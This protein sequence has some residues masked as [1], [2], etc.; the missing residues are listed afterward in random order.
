MKNTV[1]NFILI[2]ILFISCQKKD[3]VIKTFTDEQN[4]N[5]QIT[6]ENFNNR[7]E[8]LILVRE[9]VVSKLPSIVIKK[10]PER[11][12]QLQLSLIKNGE[13]ISLKDATR[14]SLQY[15]NMYQ[16]YMDKVIEERLSLSQV[17]IELQNFFEFEKTEF[18]RSKVME[19]SNM[20]NNLKKLPIG[21]IEDVRRN[22]FLTDE[23]K[24]YLT[25][26]DY[27]LEMNP[28]RSIL[29]NYIASENKNIYFIIVDIKD[30]QDT[31]LSY[32]FEYSL[33]DKS[34]KFDY[35]VSKTEMNIEN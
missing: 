20:I 21:H 1:V 15:S 12:E 2:V 3:E 9:Y 25:V 17:K 24:S 32:T 18:R 31:T 34:Y 33:T 10:Y 35:T 11:M 8:E 5:P 26:E 19:V 28:N 16:L 14:K 29:Y 7:A 30:S 6:E 22:R 23:S 27:I 4:T 13:N